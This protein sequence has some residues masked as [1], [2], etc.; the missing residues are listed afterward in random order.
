[1]GQAEVG[2]QE[3]QAHPGGEVEMIIKTYIAARVLLLNRS[4]HL[5]GKPGYYDGRS[6][7]TRE[8]FLREKVIEKYIPT[9]VPQYDRE[10]D[11]EEEELEEDLDDTS[12][13]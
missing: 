1:M 7:A 8:V 9:P 11:I 2:Q 13:E 6:I 12:D 3:T 5:E 4:R 10:D